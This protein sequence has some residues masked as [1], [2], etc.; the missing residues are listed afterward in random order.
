MNAPLFDTCMLCGRP[1]RKPGEPLC[2]AHE[3]E[4]LISL[5][6]ERMIERLRGNIPGRG[7]RLHPAGL[8]KFNDRRIRDGNV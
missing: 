3:I 8:G 4:A 5:S 1:T 2:I 6:Y 7:K